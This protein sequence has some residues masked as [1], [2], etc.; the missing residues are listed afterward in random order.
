MY[1]PAGVRVEERD[2]PRIVEATDAVI[3]PTKRSA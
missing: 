1:G 3:S 2:E